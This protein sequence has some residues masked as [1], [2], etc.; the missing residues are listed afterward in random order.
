MK[1]LS[2]FANK[3]NKK[4]ILSKCV[5]MVEHDRLTIRLREGYGLNDSPKTGRLINET[6]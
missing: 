5:R 2:H 1:L 3:R 6:V 4:I